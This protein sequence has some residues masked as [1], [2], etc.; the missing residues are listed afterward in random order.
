MYSM[1]F[2]V[3]LNLIE[4]LYVIKSIIVKKV[5]PFTYTT[6]DNVRLELNKFYELKSILI[7]MGKKLFLI[8]LKSF[9]CRG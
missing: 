4:Q 1:K 5:S 8:Y 2:P 9:Y 6:I 7:F 3:L